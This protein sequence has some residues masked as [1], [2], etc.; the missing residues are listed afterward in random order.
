MKTIQ[1]KLSDIKSNLHQQ[2]ALLHKAKDNIAK[3]N[4]A[5]RL[6]RIQVEKEKQK[7]P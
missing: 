5:V 3:S 6:A 4:E 1:E 2:K 7:K